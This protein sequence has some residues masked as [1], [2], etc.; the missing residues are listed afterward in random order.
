[1][2]KS[3]GFCLRSQ[4]KKYFKKER[5]SGVGNGADGEMIKMTTRT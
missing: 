2:G 3:R 1:M 5:V 4:G